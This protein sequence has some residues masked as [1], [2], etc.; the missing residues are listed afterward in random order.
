MSWAWLRRACVAGYVVALLWT[1]CGASAADLSAVGE[2]VEQLDTEPLARFLRQLDEEMYPVMPDFAVERIVADPGY[3]FDPQQML[4]S[5]GAFLAREVVANLGMLGALVTMAV[6]TAALDAVAAGVA[7]RAP[8]V[9]AQAV[10]RII[11]VIVGVT[12]F[13]RSA[14][15]G[16]ETVENMMG[17]IYALMPSLVTAMAASGGIVTAAVASPLM[18]AAAAAMGALVRSWVVPMLLMSTVLSLVGDL[19]GR[20]QVA[21]LAAVMRQWALLV[22]GFGSTLFVAATTVRG[23]IAKVSDAAAGRAAKFLTGSIV[24]VVGKVF[25]DAIDVIAASS[26]LVRGALG[27]FGLV[28]LVVVCLFPLLRMAGIMLAFRVAGALCQPLGDTK[29]SDALWELA[30]ALQ[31]LCVAVGTV[32]LMF[33]L[34][35]A[36]FAGLGGVLPR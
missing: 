30:E 8:A 11:L 25:S 26:G 4:Y 22:L 18:V 1:A 29:L 7:H 5:A 27:A 17:L 16:L 12:A 35:M 3:L 36:A 19:G 6:L 23:G 33:F 13:H 21:R 24:P 10:C 2:V 31:S 15:V 32:G 14:S 34:C 28:A 9:T 20:R